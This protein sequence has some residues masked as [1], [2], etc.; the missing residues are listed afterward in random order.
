LDT[1][2]FPFLLI[3]ILPVYLRLQAAPSVRDANMQRPQRFQPFFRSSNSQARFKGMVVLE[4]G[5]E[6]SRM[7]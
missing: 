6:P 3:F 4:V 7:S 1:A 2:D 5:V